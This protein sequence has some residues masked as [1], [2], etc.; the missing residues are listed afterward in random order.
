M[1]VN[2]VKVS[3][4]AERE[5]VTLWD[6]S[7]QVNHQYVDSSI[8]GFLSPIATPLQVSYSTQPLSQTQAMVS[9]RSKP[10]RTRGVSSMM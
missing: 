5:P 8:W 1:S 6:I 7:N 10:A 9:H 3:P 2:I 4:I